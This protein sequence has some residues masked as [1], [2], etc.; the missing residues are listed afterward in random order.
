MRDAAR[1]NGFEMK[2]VKKKKAVRIL[3]ADDHFVVRQGLMQIIAS[4]LPD[5]EFGEASDGNEALQAVWNA[6]WDVLLLDIS[7]PGRGGLDALKEIKL[8]QPKL[9]VIVVSMHSEDQFAIRVLKLGA[10]G[11]IRKDSAGHELVAAVAAALAGGRYITPH[12]AEK[13]AVHLSENQE[14]LLHEKLSDR[15]YQIMCL[16]GAGNTVKEIGGEL[17]LSVKTISTYRSRIIEKM[18]LK[19][20]AQIMRYTLQ[21]G[22]VDVKSPA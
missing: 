14:G 1:G 3:I 17:S 11:Y 4:Q 16:I 19:N 10:S 12:L 21:H 7:M 20:N 8:A 2:K 6:P 15:E 22:L 18:N 13:L 5:V 9:P